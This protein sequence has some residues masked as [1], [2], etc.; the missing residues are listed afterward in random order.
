MATLF[1]TAVQRLW[2][3]RALAPLVPLL[4]DDLMPPET[5]VRRKAA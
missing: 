2:K 3:S 4:C 1:G 5:P